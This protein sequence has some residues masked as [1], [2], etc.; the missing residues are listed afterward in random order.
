MTRASALLFLAA[1]PFLPAA[2]PPASST[3]PTVF[4]IG[5]STMA[6]HAVLPASPTRGWGQMF[7]PYFKDTLRVENHAMSGRSSKSFI[8]EGRWKA[9]LDR[10]TENDYVIIQ[11]GH[12]DQKNK[13]PSRFTEPAGEFTDNLARYVKETRGHKA[14]P[15]LVTPVSRAVWDKDGNFI[16][17]H[18]DYPKAVKQV[19]A[20]QKVPVL[21]LEARTRELILKLGQERSKNLFANAD[22]G[23]YEALP[24]GRSD[25][26]HFNAY[27][28]CRVCDYAAMEIKK[29]VPELAKHLR[30]GGT[31]PLRK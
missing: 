2:D 25:G 30:E 11:F 19:A 6:T 13:D 8:A 22:P 20:E 18:R 24:K 9:V 26:S 5:D 23:D 21:D 1:A 15:I 3:A 16:D 27:G 17:T 10:L 12:N 29:N 28:A 7:Q 31:D 4:M 14:F